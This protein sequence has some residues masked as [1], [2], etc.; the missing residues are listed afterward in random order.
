PKLLNGLWQMSSSAWG[1]ASHLEQRTAF[2]KLIE[3]GLVAA[4]MADHYGDA[5]L[6]WGVLRNC[7]EPKIG[8][9]VIAISKW[10]IFRPLDVPVTSEFVLSKVKER[11]RRLRGRVE[12]LQFH[13][14]NYSDKAYLSIILE[15]VKITQSHPHLVSNIGLCN[16]DSEHTEEVAKYLLEVIGEVGIVSNQVQFSLIDARP[17]IKMLEV[18]N[19]YDIKLLTYGSF[20]GG[21]ISEKWLGRKSPD[22]YSEVESLTPSQRKYFDMIMKWGTWTE[23]QA[24]LHTLQSIAIKH[25]SQSNSGRPLTLTNVAIRWVLDHREVGSVIVGTRLGVSNHVHENSGVFGFELDA[26]DRCQLKEWTSGERVRRVFG[27]VGDCG[28]EYKY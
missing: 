7:L 17:T 28:S 12:L 5:E 4:D 9:R 24:L 23:F 8:D 26:E 10:C 14:Y 25:T 15:L 16:F 20:L 13:W 2:V 22:I 21:F 6:V 19:K 1:S 11:C 18:C 3:S 27:L